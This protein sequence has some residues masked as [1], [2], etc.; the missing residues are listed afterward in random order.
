[1][2]FRQYIPQGLRLFLKLRM[3]K[4]MDVY[5]GDYYLLASRNSSA[6]QLTHEVSI[7]Q[8]I[9]KSASFDNKLHNLQKGIDAISGTV[10]QPR[11]IFSFWHLV[12]R[13]DKSNGFVL[14]RNIVSG[15]VSEDYGGGLCQL[16]SIIYHLSLRAG[17]EIRERYNHSV[18]IYKEEERFTPLGADATVVYGYKDLRVQNKLGFPVMIRLEIR[19]AHLHCS[20]HSLRPVVEREIEFQ[21]ENAE[22][23]VEVKAVDVLE[24]KVIAR[25]SYGRN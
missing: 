22:G 15:Q 10:L 13:P 4:A 16:S 9:R 3:R 19:D 2:S 1:M 5:S 21:R 7:V 17:L 23:K 25:S 20:F 8:P 14:S 18:D 11:Q 24:E 6:E 12:G